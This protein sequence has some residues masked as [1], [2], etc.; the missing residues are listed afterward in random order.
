MTTPTA[1]TSPPTTIVIFGASGD[2]TQRK[3]VPALYNLYIKERL[4]MDSHIVGFARRPYSHKEFR[5]RMREGGE[6]HSRETFDAARWEEFAP[7]LFYYQ[8]DLNE[9]TDYEGLHAFLREL[10]A[11]QP[12]HRLYYLSTAPEY[13]VTVVEMLSA[14]GMAKESKDNDAKRRIIIEKPFGHDLES[15]RE[16]NSIVLSHFREHQV[17]RID[18]Y[19]GKETAQ[20]ITFFRFSNTV[21][22][23]VWNRN[24]ID[25]VQITVAEQVDVGSRAGFYDSAGI[26][27][28]M[29][30][31]HLLQLLAL[32]AMEPPFSFSADAVRN[33]TVKVLSSIRPITDGDLLD[34]V[35]FGQYQGYQ[36]AER[37]AEGS[38]TPTYAAMRLYIDNWRW[39]GVPFYLRSG[40]ALATKVSEVLV[41]FRMPPHTIFPM[42]PG[43]SVNPDV[44]SLCIQPD[45]GMHFRFEA[46]LPGTV[47]ETRSVDMTFHY[48]D[49]CEFTAIP[50]AYERLLMD[51]IIGDATLFIR[52]DAIE[53]A[54]ELMDPIIKAWETNDSLKPTIYQ[55][56]SWGPD[57]ADSFVARDGRRWLRLCGLHENGAA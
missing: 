16:L 47:S 10:E 45:E 40:K 23:N 29:F 18:H 49:I 20:N 24:Y 44:L 51:A 21:F 41:Q 52:G 57:D 30:Q 43:K 27:R 15:A 56:G 3:L 31:N 2:L 48:N 17:Y 7:R 50:E 32:I 11:E 5:E 25:N 35:V 4:N 37:V 1:S 46:K 38:R 55:P 12:V 33:E 19:L 28:D 53:R 39:H 13:Y 14:V 9:G 26:V 8:G 54:W 34:N 36:Q 42:P 6:K 22:E